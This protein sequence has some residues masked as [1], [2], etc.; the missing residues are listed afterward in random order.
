MKSEVLGVIQAHTL[1]SQVRESNNG[2]KSIPIKTMCFVVET[3]RNA[4][5]LSF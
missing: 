5:G 1:D 2:Y 4:E 3:R